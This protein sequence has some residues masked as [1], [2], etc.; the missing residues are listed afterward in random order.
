MLLILGCGES[1]FG[2][3]L[4]AHK[5]KLPVFVSDQTIIKDEFKQM[6]I[7]LEIDFEEGGHEIAY[8]ILPTLVIKS[9][10]IPDNAKIIK[11]FAEKNIEL[12]SEIEFAYRY[13]KG[14]IIAITGSNGK[15]TTTNLCYHMLHTN[16]YHVAKVGNVG[17]SFARSL[18]L[19]DH[20]YYVLELSSFQLDTISEFRPD[21]AIIINIT[22]DHLDRYD[23]IFENYIKSKFRITLNQKSE[24]LLILNSNDQTIRKYL[25][26][27]PINAKVDWLEVRLN[28]EEDVIVN[29]ERLVSLKN[30]GLK[31][32]HNAFNAGCAARAAH[33][34]GLGYKEIQ[35]SIDSFVNDPHRLEL[36]ET[37]NGVSYI[38]DSKATNVD[39]VYWALDA[40]KGKVIWIAGGQD[41]GNDYSQLQSLVK[42]KV[43]ALVALG[44][45]N[46]KLLEA[47][48][49]LVPVF[50]THDMASAVAQSKKLAEDGDAVLLSPACASFDLF[51]N[52]MHRGD[53]FKEEVLKMKLI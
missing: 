21:V 2:A 53:L 25:G 44:V 28:E 18:A 42:S 17:Y 49:E 30:S 37:L 29:N 22:P 12:I 35:K 6:F 41:K 5:Q 52:Y 27:V 43:K 33:F 45:D 36:V 13:C 8:D 14:K 15:T 20:D 11:H 51:N 40:M 32:N 47:F 10:G 39:S 50:D 26:I 48:S 19:T 24:D 34:M 4:L 46:G 31:G 9:P 23:Y 38:N 3:A 16:G 7:D 1:G